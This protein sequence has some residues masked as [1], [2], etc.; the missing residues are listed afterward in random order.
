MALPA[1]TTMASST[2]TT[3]QTLPHRTIIPHRTQSDAHWTG[4]ARKA[5]HPHRNCTKLAASP[6]PHLSATPLSH[7][8]HPMAKVTRTPESRRLASTK[9]HQQSHQRRAGE[10]PAHSTLASQFT[11]TPHPPP[12]PLPPPP[13]P[14]PLPPTPTTPP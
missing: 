13:P 14:P 2:P 8:S 9:R 3:P 5:L 12:P 11:T 7:L 4:P 10:Q 1:L 6:K